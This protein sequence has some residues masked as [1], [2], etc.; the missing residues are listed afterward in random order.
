VSATLVSLYSG[1][2]GLDLGLEA[3]GFD[4]RLCVE[5]DEDA[6]ETLAMRGWRLSNPGDVHELLNAGTL[7]EQAGLSARKVTLLAGGPPCQPWSKSGYWV[8]GS[9]KRLDDPRA[10]TL[11]AYM[12]VVEDLLPEVILLENVRGL[13]LGG[14]DDAMGLLRR[15]LGRVNKTHGTRYSAVTLHMNAADFGAPQIRERLF[16]VAHCEGRE[17]EEP[18]ATHG[19]SEPH[20]TA[21]D[22][23]GDL[24]V[25]EESP[26]V[27]MCGKWA[28]L[29]ASIP[30]GRNYLWHTPGGGGEPLFGARTR[31]WSFL[32]KLAKA[33]PAWT[34]QANPGPATGPFHWNNRRLALKELA[35]LQTFPK[36]FRFSGE[37]R[38][39][40]R[41]IGNAVP[42]I[43][44]EVLGL[45]IRNQLLGDSV[46]TR[47][48]EY[49]I[50][51]RRECPGPEPVGAVPAE[52]LHLRGK[53][54][55]HP[56]EG[57][58]P[59]ATRRATP[60]RAQNGRAA[61]VAVR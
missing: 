58:G 15:E 48:T 39:V 30:E 29:I 20:R 49:I 1:A 50:R 28:R 9:T 8:D 12:K 2:G 36:S 6:R 22:A 17:L 54:A 18:E 60:E 40:L 61:A 41:Q 59:G 19:G 31:F 16:V 38:S 43:L 21:W 5:F 11:A 24:D 14:K 53:H 42:P 27:R 10:T 52:Y 57:K 45:A 7:K 51:H 33:E 13:A 55:P 3:A 4:V 47:P 34:I 32:L 35:R 46:S 26:E 56:G 23:I 37:Y 44:G 25:D